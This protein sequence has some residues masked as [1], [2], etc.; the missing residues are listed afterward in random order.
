MKPVPEADHGRL[1]SLIG[2]SPESFTALMSDAT[3]DEDLL[4]YLYGPVRVTTTTS[5]DDEGS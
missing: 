3:V 5:D 2:F 4:D 1:G